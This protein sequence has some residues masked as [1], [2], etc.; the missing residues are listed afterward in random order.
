MRLNPRFLACAVIL[1]FALIS[2]AS[3]GETACVPR[4]PASE[5]LRCRN[6]TCISIPQ[7]DPLSLPTE[8]PDKSLNGIPLTDDSKIQGETKRWD[9]WPIYPVLTAVGVS[10][11]F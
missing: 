3:V 8:P 6:L 9:Y 10:F 4:T 5:G 2:E 1:A 11:N 7:C